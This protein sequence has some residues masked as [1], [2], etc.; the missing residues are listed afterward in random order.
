MIT[1][2]RKW[3]IGVAAVVTGLGLGFGFIG[4]L[5]R[6]RVFLPKYERAILEAR[7]AL[8]A[9]RV[10]DALVLSKQASEFDESKP[11]AFVVQ[12][13]ALLQL[14]EPS[15]AGDAFTLALSKAPLRQQPKIQALIEAAGEDEKYNELRSKARDALTRAAYADAAEASFN[16]WQLF[17]SRAEAGFEA[18]SINGVIERYDRCR[19]VLVELRRSSDL[20]VQ[21]AAEQ[22]LSQVE[23]LAAST[24]KSK[25]EYAD[26]ELERKRPNLD[27]VTQAYSDA[28]DLYPEKSEPRIGLAAMAV[29]SGSPEEAIEIL[30]AAAQAHSLVWQDLPKRAELRTMADSEDFQRFLEDTFGPRI[31]AIVVARSTDDVDDQLALFERCANDFPGDPDCASGLEAARMRR[32]RAKGAAK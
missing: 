2:K 19:A 18:V 11:E 14:D 27:R 6:T 1:N 28:R 16:A 31:A 21:R 17:P 15:A 22:Q 30:E 13:L 10:A 26:A 23:P 29:A 25:L 3:A 8:T 32:A 9:D 5:S 20:R 12:G 4:A 7:D 24:Y